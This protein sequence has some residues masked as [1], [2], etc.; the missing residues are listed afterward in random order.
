MVYRNIPSV[1]RSLIFF[2]SFLFIGAPGRIR[3]YDVFHEGIGFTDRR[4]RH[5]RHTDAYLILLVAPGRIELPT[6]GF[7]VPCSAN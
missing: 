2:L 1:N 3:T 5:T 4:L 7:S 6:Q